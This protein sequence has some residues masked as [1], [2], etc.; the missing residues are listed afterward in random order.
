MK[1]ASLDLQPEFYV[2]G[3][4]LRNDAPSYVVR[5][6]DCEL[7][8]AL[9][10]GELCFVLTARQTGKSS[11]MVRTASRLRGDGALAV[12]LDL[13]ALGQ[14]VTSAQW[15][16]AL[17]QSTAAQIGI[18]L[19]AFEDFWERQEQCSPLQCWLRFLLEVLLPAT[20]HRRII[21]FMDEIDIVRSLPFSTDEFFASIRELY[22]RRAE[23]PDLARLT[24]CL[25]GVASPSDLI[26]NTQATPFNVGRR[27]ELSDF[28]LGEAAP[29]ATGLAADPRA[30]REALSR[31]LYWTGGHPYLT[32]RLCLKVAQRGATAHKTVQEVCQEV[33]SR[34]HLRNCDDN[35]LFVRE[36]LLHG[37]KDVS[38]LLMLYERV[39]RGKKVVDDDASPLVTTLRLSGVTK[40]DNGRLRVRNRIYQRTFDRQWVR[41]SLPQAEL[42]RQRVAYRKGLLRATAI[43]TLVVAVVSVLAYIAMREG[44]E[45]RHLLYA[46]H[47]NLA[48]QALDQDNVPR[49]IELLAS[50]IPNH[51]EADLRG[52]EWYKLWNESHS[53]QEILKVEM[54][55]P[56]N[57]A[58][59]DLGGQTIIAACS[60][61]TLRWYDSKT[62]RE[63][64]RVMVSA[65]AL[66]GLALSPDGSIIAVGTEDGSTILWDLRR[67][68]APARLLANH[69]KAIP[70]DSWDPD[71]APSFSPDGKLVASTATADGAVFDVGN[72]ERLHLVEG[73]ESDAVRQL[74]FSPKGNTIALARRGA[75]EIWNA[76]LHQRLASFPSYQPNWVEFS[77]DGRLV[78]SADTD[79]MIRI[80]NAVTGKLVMTLRG[81]SGLV[82]GIAFSPDG[83]WLASGGDDRTLRLWNLQT[84]QATVVAGHLGAIWTVAFSPDGKRILTS[85]A[86]RTLRVWDA[87]APENPDILTASDEVYSLA[88]SSDGSRLFAGTNDGTVIACDLRANTIVQRW[89]AGERVEFVGFA[90]GGSILVAG[91]HNH[92]HLWDLRSGKAMATEVASGG[93]RSLALNGDHL[94]VINPAQD[95]LTVWDVATG[96]PT[97]AAK[98]ENVRAA[99][100]SLAPD[101]R[102]VAIGTLEGRVALFSSLGPPVLIDLPG[103][104]GRIYTLAFSP[105][106]RYLAVGSA[107]DTI[108]ILDVKRRAEVR[109]LRGHNGDIKGEQFSPDGRRLASASDDGTVKLWDMETGEE[110]ITELVSRMGI[111]TL[112]FSP[113]GSKLAVAGHDHKI[114]VWTGG[115]H[116]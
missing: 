102:L 1:R 2:A 93:Y 86:D 65:R 31:V 75:I 56:A 89:N 42:R 69:R 70:L 62:G 105:D 51:G 109:V 50:E 20:A 44:K 41:A 36:R 10:A 66:Y 80:H 97:F 74:V 104:I 64:S 12:V 110:L 21:I 99:A 3:G 53:R 30:G 88:F 45:N 37:H 83:K 32:Q 84:R 29:L 8:E 100:V 58:V 24:F 14:E 6:A 26:R 68:G 78:A 111:E 67:R 28:S 52:F 71:F 61:G 17:A 25:L 115:K 4:T 108:R 19:D 81:H 48:Q 94:A 82:Q 101:D 72:H 35:L 22:N 60:D 85:A 95:L 43:A 87:A 98:L 40:V 107:D 27:I 54:D 73:S 7:Y 55:V 16:Y 106:S 46:A 57:A 33:F 13:T 23:Q 9:H 63:L 5:G 18:S 91:G 47:M 49:G 59:W 92:V 79:H 76:S 113:D 90:Q 39:W 103:H 112:A 116:D 38:A 114:Q 11:L 15:Y 96:H 77:T 34:A